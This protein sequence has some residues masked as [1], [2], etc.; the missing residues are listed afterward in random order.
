MEESSGSYG[1]TRVGKNEDTTLDTVSLTT[2]FAE[3]NRHVEMNGV[4]TNDE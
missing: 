1:D 4:L 2:G 3:D